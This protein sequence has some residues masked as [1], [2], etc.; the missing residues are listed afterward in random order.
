MEIGVRK[1][2]RQDGG[3][4][5]QATGKEGGRYYFGQGSTPEAAKADLMKNYEREKKWPRLQRHY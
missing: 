2:M 1:V 4:Y 5:Y 3:E